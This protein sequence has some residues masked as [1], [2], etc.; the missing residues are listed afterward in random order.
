MGNTLQVGVLGFIGGFAGGKATDIRL[1]EERQY[2]E[3][4]RLRKEESAI[5]KQRRLLQLTNE[6]N[7]RFN[8]E[9]LV[10][11]GLQNQD[12]SFNLPEDMDPR[13][14]STVNETNIRDVMKSYRADIITQAKEGRKPRV[15]GPDTTVITGEAVDA[16]LAED[17][18]YITPGR[19]PSAGEI[20]TQ[21]N[22]VLR[23]VKDELKTN[24]PPL[25]NK[26]R[27]ILVDSGIDDI[28]K[29][30]ESKEAFMSL[31]Q[32]MAKNKVIA[33]A[34]DMIRTNPSAFGGL[35]VGVVVDDIT[36][37]QTQIIQAVD[38]ASKRY[39]EAFNAA[40]ITD[41]RERRAYARTLINDGT[42]VEGGGSENIKQIM[43]EGGF[44][45]AS[46]ENIMIRSMLARRTVL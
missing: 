12:G 7:I 21:W 1:E 43:T 3:A 25:S 42:P 40:G 46:I 4:L 34:N 35:N 30:P 41:K 39:I 27:E 33:E 31:T 14:A 15:R 32:D 26:H 6:S 19:K 45:N 17:G 24:T 9:G 8:K 10:N 13:I 44:W 37:K 2:S 22:V 28:M 5:L 23:D 11:E 36:A 38:A 29:Y 18:T 16:L 20:R